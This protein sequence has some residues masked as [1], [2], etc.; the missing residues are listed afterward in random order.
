MKLYAPISITHVL[1]LSLSI[2]PRIVALHL[3]LLGYMVSIDKDETC[4]AI[5]PFLFLIAITSILLS[6]PFPIGT[7]HHC[8]NEQPNH[9]TQ[10]NQL[11]LL[12]PSYKQMAYYLNLFVLITLHGLLIHPNE[13]SQ[14]LITCLQVARTF[15]IYFFVE[16]FF[17]LLA[18]YIYTI[19]S[20]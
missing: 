18:T 4:Y 14:N 20:T 19:L 6:I 8:I 13:C 2:P 9:H 15:C 12:L 11:C 7:L 5:A 3:A 1:P 16:H 17:F 10:H